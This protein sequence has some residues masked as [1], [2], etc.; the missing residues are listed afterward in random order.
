M[1]G[2]SS[3]SL[4]NLR[5]HLPFQPLPPDAIVRVPAVGYAGSSARRSGDS[6]SSVSD[7]ASDSRPGP[8]LVDR[9]VFD[10]VRETV[11]VEGRPS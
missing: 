6:L 10:A 4:T 1:T 7:R 3:V 9:P 2:L 5:W 11:A 8:L